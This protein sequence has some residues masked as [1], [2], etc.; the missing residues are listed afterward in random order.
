MSVVNGLVKISQLAEQKQYQQAVE[1]HRQIVQSANF[2]QISAFMPGL[3]VLL[4]ISFQ[5]RV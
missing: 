2:S 4:Q 1:V 5:L 3:K